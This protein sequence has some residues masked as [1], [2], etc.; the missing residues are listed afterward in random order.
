MINF[1]K[2]ICSQEG[3]DNIIDALNLGHISGDGKYTK[4]CHQWLEKYCKCSKV[5]LTHSCTAALEMSAILSN[6]NSDDEIIILH[7]IVLLKFG[8]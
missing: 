8:N 2:A 7:N 3:I 1:N 6:L 5:L 4:L